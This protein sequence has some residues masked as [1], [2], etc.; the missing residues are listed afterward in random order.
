M[1][2][3]DVLVSTRSRAGG[4]GGERHHL[5]TES[6]EEGEELVVVEDETS[7]PQAHLVEVQ[8]CRSTISRKNSGK[9]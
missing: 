8:V 3:R 2:L 5:A 4:G 1:I 9:V 6:K 7:I